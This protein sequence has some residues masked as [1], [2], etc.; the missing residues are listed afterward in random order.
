M[1]FKPIEIIINAKDNASA[2]FGRLQT[3][4]VTVGAALLSY[5]GV[6]A[7][8]GA[9]KGAA[10]FEEAM[11]RVKAATDGTAEEMAALRKAAEDAGAN[12]KYTSVEAAAALENLAKAGLSANDAIAALP[13]VLSLA[14]AGDLA[15]GQSAEFV[16]KAVMGMG[17]SFQDAGRVA[18]VLAK[19]A[20]ATNTSVEGL[21]Q[22]LSYAAPVANTLGLSLESTVAIIGK[23]ADAGID[24]SRAGTALNSIL[25]Q[26]ANP[27]SQFR[28]ELGAAGIVTTDFEKAL[29]QLAAKGPEGARAINA[30]GLEAG[31]ALRALLNQGMGALDDLTGKLREAEGS[32]AAT[33][34]TMSDNLNG[35]I[36][37]LS[38]VWDSLT[39]ALATPVLPVLK[40]AFD[41]LALSLRGIVSDG[42]VTRFGESIATAFKNGIDYI[43]QFLQTIDFQAV[44]VKLQSF[45]DETNAAF[46]KV[47]EYA[48]NAGNTLQTVWGVM[49]A[50]TNAV[51]TVIYGL[52]SVFAEVASSIMTGVSKLRQGLAT[53]TFGKLSE[54]F[55]LAAD[56]AVLAAEGFSDAA[57]AMRDKAAEAM[58]DTADAAQ[59]ARAGFAGLIGASK[60]AGAAASQS[61]L[62]FRE[63]AAAIEEAGRKS[64]EAK[65]AS[66]DKAA[67]DTAAAESVKR[68]RAEYSELIASGNLQAAAEKLREIDK[69][70]RGVADSAKLAAEAT[71][72]IDQAYADLGLTTGTELKRLA[73]QGRAAFSQLEKDGTQSALRMADAFKVMADRAIAANGG[74]VPAWLKLEASAKGYSIA[75]D[76]AG[77]A[78]V[79]TDKATRSATGSMVDSLDRVGNAT[80]RVS[81]YVRDL[82]SDFGF[83]ADAAIKLA[84]AGQHLAAVQAQKNQ[85]TADSSITKTQGQTNA[86]SNLVPAFETVEELRAWN[87]EWKRQYGEMNPFSVKSSGALGNYQY[88]LTQFAVSEAEKA[89]KL[90]QASATGKVS[91][92]QAGGTTST[93]RT[94]NLNING[95]ALGAVNTDAAGEAALE[96]LLDELER[97]KALAGQ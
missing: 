69:A 92:G 15:L 4:I 13:A 41:E 12:T 88:D 7:F 57:Q 68:L 76:D 91:S 97:S 5:F 73:D 11:S 45:A 80:R 36:K 14:Q 38:S 77:K 55:K 95:R 72:L 40:Q 19:G 81:G 86:I 23:F 17:L 16:T 37:G 83:T 20:N 2:V 70:Q 82:G 27:A 54:S 51:L 50:G 29:H 79:N 75:L 56:D 3:M 34:K 63:V 39:N 32:A 61:S 18:D 10:D 48:T 94:I 62:N 9:V 35:S 74:I 43:R 85:D 33:A 1:A 53:V 42:T 78:V 6:S 44:G 87:E 24:A 64:A 60:E 21:A 58:Q 65:Q 22:A 47:G 46:T 8:V 67:A 66:L 30:V 90:K 89:I 93:T 28:K 52:G 31:P 59:T 96:R 71:A 25:S 49:T 84:Q 26:F